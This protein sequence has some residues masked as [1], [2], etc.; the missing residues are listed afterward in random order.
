METGWLILVGISAAAWIV[1]LAFAT[2]YAPTGYEDETGYGQE[3][4]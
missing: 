4:K 3:D 1:W 2:H